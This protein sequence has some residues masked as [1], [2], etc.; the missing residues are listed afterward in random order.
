MTPSRQDR[1]RERAY[2]I[3]EA[4]GRPHGDHNAHWEQAQHELEASEQDQP[5]EPAIA[6]KAGLVLDKSSAPQE[7]LPDEEEGEP[8]AQRAKFDD[9]VQNKPA[10][11]MG[12]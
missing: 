6:G 8:S 4:A 5:V 2:Q 9:P 1:I 12:H 10:K 7:A 11:Q 3:W